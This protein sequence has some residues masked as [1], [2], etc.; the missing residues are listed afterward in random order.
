MT[1]STNVKADIVP[2]TSEYALRVRSWIDSEETYR[3][4]CQGKEFPPPEDLVESWQRVDIA[5][6]IMLVERRPVAYGELWDRPVEQAAEIGHLIVDPAKRSRGY[7]TKMLRLLTQRAGQ[8]LRV[9]KVMLHLFGGDEVVL[10]CYL[11]AGF[12]IVATTTAG[13]GLRMEQRTDEQ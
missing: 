2:Y 12:E 5:S 8:R 7:G 3:S 9:R 11:K 13:E 10:G 1:D 4:V 6:Y